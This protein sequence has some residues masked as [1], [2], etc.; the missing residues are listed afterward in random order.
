MKVWAK[1][2]KKPEFLRVPG[3]GAPL[4]VKNALRQGETGR[5]VLKR[6]DVAGRD[7]RGGTIN[8]S[9]PSD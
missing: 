9:N 8:R 1:A 4:M 6:H 5:F 2:S 3:R 7:G